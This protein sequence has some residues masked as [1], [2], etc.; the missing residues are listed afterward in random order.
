M[1]TKSLTIFIAAL[2]A[3]TL[4][5][6]VLALAS[7]NTIQSAYAMQPAPMQVTQPIADVQPVYLTATLLI[8]ELP[9]GTQI[10][11]VPSPSYQIF[12]IMSILPQDG[13]FT[14]WLNNRTVTAGSRIAAPW[15]PP[16][17]RPEGRR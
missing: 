6:G 9:D 1:K 11:L 2:L 16:R 8:E 4:L 3:F 12:D 15:P 17:L 10:E 5:T 14:M 7:N 13:Q